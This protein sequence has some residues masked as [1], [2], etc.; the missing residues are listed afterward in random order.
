MRLSHSRMGMILTCPMTYKVAYKMGI[1]LK[2]TKPALRIG[3][4]VHYGI[5]HETEDLSEFYKELGSFSQSNQYTKE[6]ELAE[7]MVMGYL[8]Q[9]NNIFAD[10]LIDDET[11]EPLELYE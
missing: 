10:L 3:S 9:K 7:A 5:E 1:S 2:E 8:N 6:Q 11:G 4:A